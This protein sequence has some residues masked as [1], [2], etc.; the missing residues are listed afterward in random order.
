MDKLQAL[1]KDV[2][3]RFLDKETL[4]DQ[5][6]RQ[7]GRPVDEVLVEMENR[8]ETFELL[9]LA[10]EGLEQTDKRI[11][12]RYIIDN[13]TMADIAKELQMS[14]QAVSKRL[15]QLPEKIFKKF[16]KNGCKHGKYSLEEKSIENFIPGLSIP[17]R[18]DKT[19]A[20]GFPSDLMERVGN[21]G[22]WNYKTKSGRRVYYSRKKCM[23]PEYYEVCFKDTKTACP[24]CYKK[25]CRRGDYY[26]RIKK[27]TRTNRKRVSQ[28]C[29]RGAC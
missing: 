28:A 1:L 5:Y 12:E 8:K 11:I 14:Q 25:K 2:R 10:F 29:C 20:V 3:D 6:V 22:Y 18:A 9:N 23:L 15:S 27:K 24:L 4:I 17:F 26:T 13:W 16:I 7:E 19:N 21:G